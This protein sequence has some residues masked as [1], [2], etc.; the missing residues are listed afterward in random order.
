MED[1]HTAF[2][3]SLAMAS[4]VIGVVVGIAA[5]MIGEDMRAQMEEDA[6]YDRLSRRIETIGTPLQSQDIPLE[7][8]DAPLVVRSPWLTGI[9]AGVATFVIGRMVML[10]LTIEGAARSMQGGRE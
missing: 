9:V 7:P 1:R 10:A 8:R 3:G 6:A 4:V 5:G 2:V